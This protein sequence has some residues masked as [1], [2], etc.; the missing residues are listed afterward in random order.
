MKKIRLFKNL[1]GSENV[2]PNRYPIGITIPKRLVKD[3]Y[4]SLTERLTNEAYEKNLFG[5]SASDYSYIG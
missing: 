3:L 1:K 2:E 5:F 4:K